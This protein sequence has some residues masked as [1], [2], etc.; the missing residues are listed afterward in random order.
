MKSIEQLGVPINVIQ[1]SRRRTL[2]ILVSHDEIT[3]RVPQQLS[4][5]T[6]E[7]LISKKIGWIKTKLAYQQQHAPIQH[8]LQAGDTL[9]LLDETIFL[10]FTETNQITRYA[11]NQLWLP[12]ESRQHLTQKQHLV[13][14]WY[15]EQANDYLPSRTLY[16]ADMVGKQPSA[17][18]VKSYKSRW[19]SCS[20]KGVVSYNWQIMMAPK[21]AVDYVIIHELCHLHELNHSPQYWQWVARFMPNYQTYQCWFKENAHRLSIA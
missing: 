9:P 21:R 20:S 6:I 13:T 19:G 12:K 5:K 7:T 17:I 1:S 10:G 14:Q 11:D 18:Q 8:P 16:W 2:S 3:I 15:L 4:S